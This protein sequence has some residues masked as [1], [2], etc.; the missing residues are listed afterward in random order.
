MAVGHNGAVTSIGTAARGCT[1]G[2]VVAA[3]VMM[4]GCVSTVSGIAL[5]APHAAPI[6]VPS[7][8]AAKL[9]DVL[10]SVS[11]L[12]GIMGSTKMDVTSELQQMTDHSEQVSDPDCLGAIYGAEEPVYAASGWTAMRDQVER[13]PG[14]DNEHWVEQTAVLYPSADKA[15]KFFDDS[16]SSWE[17]CSGYSVSVDDAGATYLWQIDNLASEDTSITQMTAQA[18]ANGW[19][20]QHA[21]SV[22]SNVTVEAW[23]CGYSIKDEAATIAKEMISN[24]AK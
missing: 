21:L 10:L 22:V 7:L 16:K 1:F 4:S 12:N 8:T 15:Q 24:A 23:G 11:E 9:G 20:C 6:D 17:K 18:E 2:V 13:E 19:A 3:S 14:E 5:R